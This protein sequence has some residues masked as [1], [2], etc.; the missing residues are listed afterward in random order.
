VRGDVS[1]TNLTLSQVLSTTR[2]KEACGQGSKSA[3]KP[4][5]DGVY[6]SIYKSK[7]DYE[8][9]QQHSIASITDC[10]VQMFALRKQGPVL[11][12]LVVQVS[13]DPATD[14]LR[15]R[16][17]SRTA[18]L[19][20]TKDSGPTTLYFRSADD[21]HTLNDWARYLSALIQPGLPER[22]SMMQSDRPPMSPLTPVSPTFSNPFAGVPRDAGEYSARPSSGK[23]GTRPPVFHSH[24]HRPSRDRPMTF[25]S[26][27][28]SL[29]SRTSDLS[30]H[31]SSIHAMGMGYVMHNQHYTTVLPTDLPSPATTV[32]DYQGEYMLGWTSAQ[33]RS[34]TLSSPVKGRGSVSSQA[35]SLGQQSN[36]QATPMSSS[37]PIPRE[38]ILDRAF[39]MRYIPGSDRDVPGE[40]KLSSLAR[41]DALMREAEDR[42]QKPAE[43]AAYPRPSMASTWE[44]DDDSDSD[45]LYDAPDGHEDS[46][47]DD[48]FEGQHSGGTADVGPSTHQPFH[49]LSNRHSTMSHSA[50]TSMG[51]RSDARDL[52]Y[53]LRPQT[54][55]S[56]RPGM[57]QRTASQPQVPLSL[58]IP[59]SPICEEPTGRTPNE[60]RHSTSST[61]RLSFNDFT[62]RL[63][64]TSSLLL[65]QSN[66]S[67]GSSRGSAEIECKQTTPRNGPQ[68]LPRSPRDQ[69]KCT[70]RGSIGVFGAGEG[71]FL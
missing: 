70:W 49:Y 58:D 30:S 12:T 31:A 55:H 65:V 46:S 26:E 17:S 67:N 40:E 25:S 38:T 10:T 36:H 29:R 41:F 1:Q 47:D 54:S 24:S 44:E 57:A 11:P 59:V 43:D 23:E 71:G 52:E 48:V 69:D 2:I 15:K 19:T 62:K 66:V 28:P 27:T 13:P 61:K 35:H 32:G 8:A 34:S 39:Q 60:K 5:P 16:R 42:R 21:Q 18:G 63:S 64:S 7:E 22:P 9:V 51:L 4:L 56:R 14:K 45:D 20:T 33:G 68:T 37:P 3:P 53:G 6:L 50:R